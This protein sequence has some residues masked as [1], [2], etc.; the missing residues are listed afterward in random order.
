M[1]PQARIGQVVVIFGPH[2]TD[3][4]VGQAVKHGRGERDIETSGIGFA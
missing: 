3:S 1:L 4:Q 2:A